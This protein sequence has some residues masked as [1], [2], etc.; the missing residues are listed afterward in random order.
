M[1]IA[2]TAL[3]GVFFGVLLATS[4]CGKKSDADS[5][6]AAASAS[7]SAAAA[8][9]TMPTV[10]ATATTTAPIRPATADAD[11]AAIRN[12]CAAIRSASSSAKATD[13]PKFDGA[14]AACEGI[15]VGVKNGSSTRAGAIGA[16]RA[17]LK[18]EPL[19]AA[20]NLVEGR[21]IL[22]TGT[23]VRENH[24]RSP[25][26]TTRIS[27]VLVAAALPLLVGFFGNGAV[28][29]KKD[30]PPPPLPAATETAAPPPATVQ[31]APPPD[32]AGDVV[33]ADADAKKY[34][35]PAPD[36][37]GLRACCA[38]LAQNA[39]SMPPPQNLYAAS[40]ASYCQAA[41]ASAGTSGAAG[42]LAGIRSAL[43]GAAMPAA[44]H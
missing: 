25:M 20:C 15:A 30:E 32:D 4:G 5:S 12:C 28:G 39:A 37:T 11:S 24:A 14:A 2:G 22:P 26:K 29:C 35:G 13:K 34:T 6:A 43:K 8:A 41:I 36:V 3:W 17:S 27:A 42:V 31:L 21:K 10:T 1:K 16:I 18:G 33:D 7:A 23:F 19:P 38:A 40:A 44:C 9:T